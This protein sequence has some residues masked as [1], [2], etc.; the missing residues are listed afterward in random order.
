MS[1]PFL[2][3]F[4]LKHFKAVRDSGS[5]K[6]TP[7]TV[8]IGNNGSGKSSI[9]E[10]LET[11]QA[12]VEHGLDVA[13]QPWR[14]FEHVWHQG[15]S[16]RLSQPGCGRCTHANPMS[17]D[18]AGRIRTGS[19]SA[20]LRVNA[21]PA[22]NELFIE[23]ERVVIKNQLEMQMANPNWGKPWIDTHLLG[24]LSRSFPSPWEPRFRSTVLVARS[25]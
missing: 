1:T 6:F 19:F 11:L 12:I 22:A 24:N 16:H 5:I 15:V 13:M 17:F 2:R 23:S 9:T 20:A 7:L 3:S 10:G 8:F 18:L 4:R 14:G 25:C 21:G